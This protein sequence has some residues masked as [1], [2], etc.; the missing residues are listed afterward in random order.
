MAQLPQIAA[1][2]LEGAILELA[3]QLQTLEAALN[4]PADRVNISVDADAATAS[5][6]ID[7]PISFSTGASGVTMAARTYV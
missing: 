2:T 5:I 3:V 7:M 4:P 1:T 6:S